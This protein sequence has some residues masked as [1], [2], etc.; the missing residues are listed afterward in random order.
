MSSVEVSIVDRAISSGQTERMGT[1][2]K[3]EYLECKNRNDFIT[4]LL[5]ICVIACFKF[6]RRTCEFINRDSIC[7]ITV[8]EFKLSSNY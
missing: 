7:A 1:E 3:M 5:S 6:D 8:S 2:R 4:G